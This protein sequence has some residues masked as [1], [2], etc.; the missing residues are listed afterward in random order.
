MMPKDAPSPTTSTPPARIVPDK[1]RAGDEVRVL[2]L[3]RSLGGLKQYPGISDADIEFGRKRVESL[4]LRVSFGRHVMETNAHLTISV[5]ARLEDLY[6]ALNDAAVKGILAVSGG[7][8]A[9]QLLNRLDF[10][11]FAAHPRILCGYSDIGFLCNALF[12]RTRVVT[13]YG[14]NFSSFMN[15]QCGDYTLRHF[16]ACLFDPQPLEAVPSSEWS[17]DDW[18]KDQEN[19]H[20]H[21]NDG[22]WGFNAGEAEGTVLG[23]SFLG[24]NLLQGSG[25]FPPLTDAILFL[26]H[27][28]EGKATLMTLDMGIRAL[29]LQPEFRNV[30]GMVIGRFARNARIDRE[31]MAA[32]IQDIPE[33][34]GVP[35]IANCDFGHTTPMLTLPIGGRCRIQVSASEARITMTTH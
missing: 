13:Y 17:D 33:L 11:R 6:D 29:T 31:K 27:P 34:A 21:P 18:V 32:L 2:A 28:S 35:V 5:E 20:F 9:I 30:R 1:L 10:E 22:W 8:G 14:P 12:T 3:S 7:I 16:Q 15:R 26:E 24:L 19:R 4:G 25:F 23:G